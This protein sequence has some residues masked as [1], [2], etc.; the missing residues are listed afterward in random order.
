MFSS[1][2]EYFQGRCLRGYNERIGELACRLATFYG[3]SFYRMKFNANLGGSQ[4][5]GI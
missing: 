3:F 5:T 1:V 2:A 4:T